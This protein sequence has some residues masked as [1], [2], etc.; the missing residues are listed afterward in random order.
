MPSGP[1]TTLSHK[2]VQYH[3]VFLR[4]HVPRRF[5]SLQVIPHRA[6]APGVL[7]MIA[8]GW[9]VGRAWQL[10]AFKLQM[11]REGAGVNEAA[12][13]LVDLLIAPEGS[14]MERVSSKTSLIAAQ[15]ASV[16]TT[17]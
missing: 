2:V 10:A 5:A 8:R 11:D 16:S 14:R 7:M 17:M 9:R 12:A 6:R 3:C 15:T 1:G 13:E 4:L